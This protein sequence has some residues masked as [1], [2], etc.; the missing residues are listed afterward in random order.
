MQIIPPED[1]PLTGTNK[2]V[3]IFDRH[4]VIGAYYNP[5]LTPPEETMFESG[6]IFY[7]YLDASEKFSTVSQDMINQGKLKIKSRK[8]DF[9]HFENEAA[10]NIPTDL[11]FETD[12]FEK[13][14][15]AW[16]R[17]LIQTR[18]IP[19]TKILPAIERASGWRDEETSI[20]Y[21][22][23]IQFS[24][25]NDPLGFMNIISGQVAV[26]T[27][28]KSLFPGRPNLD[29]FSDIDKIL[30]NSPLGHF[31][32]ITPTCNYLD[33]IV[34]FDPEFPQVSL[35]KF[36]NQYGLAGNAIHQK[37]VAYG[38]KVLY[39]DIITG[40]TGFFGYNID[41][42]FRKFG[43]PYY[44]VI[45]YDKFRLGNK[46]SW[47]SV[48]E[49]MKEQVKINNKMY[50]IRERWLTDKVSTQEKRLQVYFSSSRDS[51]IQWLLLGGRIPLE[52]SVVAES[53]LR[54]IYPLY[55]EEIYQDFMKAI[56]IKI[57]GLIITA[58]ITYYTAGSGT[59]VLAM[60]A[61]VIVPKLIEKVNIPFAK[62]EMQMVMNLA[63][64]SALNKFST[65]TDQ[66][67]K[68]SAAANFLVNSLEV[69]LQNIKD[70]SISFSE[71]HR[72]L[73]HYDDVV[74]PRQQMII[75]L[76][77]RNKSIR[78]GEFLDET[79]NTGVN[80]ISIASKEIKPRPSFQIAQGMR[81]AENLSKENKLDDIMKFG[82]L[83][84]AGF[85]LYKMLKK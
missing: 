1:R 34:F 33:E 6:T 70:Q 83:G 68:V 25:P 39:S 62:E 75:E 59:A 4:V 49:D 21:R 66:S 23:I 41:V 20:L 11:V 22:T 44:Y 37:M 72:A 15:A 29:K 48:F 82:A 77:G 14:F 32:P 81:I 60:L 5:K 3:F 26:H 13:M 63:F 18:S 46:Y 52:Y 40:R 10:L 43:L 79:M 50:N 56:A 27:I 36:L 47:D 16:S 61:S 8:N 9:R 7:D 78:Y 58:A 2:D 85:V 42:D 69:D 31:P 51:F 38:K 12:R 30:L 53:L 64:S 76:I 17:Y 84:L 24:V 35:S 65:E 71:F 73:T 67:K 55:F 80:A 54:P 57:V 45:D 74:L 19:D 28:L